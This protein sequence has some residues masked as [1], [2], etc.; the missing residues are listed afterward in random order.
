MSKLFC[1]DTYFW[2][3]INK[4]NKKVSGNIQARNIALAKFLLTKKNI[5]I[6]KIRKKLF[7][8]S[9]QFKIIQTIKSADV[10]IFIEHLIM[11][12]KSGMNLTTALN[13][14]LEVTK[15]HKFKKV[16]AQI[17]NDLIN[18]QSFYQA[19]NKY[20][21][22][23]D[24]L[25]CSLID[26][27]E[28]SSKLETVLIKLLSYKQHSQTIKRKLKKA[29]SYPLILLITGLLSIICIFIF[30]IPQFEIIFSDFIHELPALTKL[31]LKLAQF[32]N[33]KFLLILMI[34]LGIFFIFIKY[35]K[36]S[37]S[38]AIFLDKLILKLPF[39]DFL[40]LKITVVRFSYC[41]HIALDSGLPLT[42][43]LD[44]IKNSNNLFFNQCV[45]RI[46]NSITS[47][48]TL[49]TALKEVEVFPLLFINMIAVGEASGN[50]EKMLN[51]ITIM[52]E[53]EIDNCINIFLNILEPMIITILG[54]LLSILIIALYLPIFKLGSIF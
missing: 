43:A 12:L 47:G 37:L 8:I 7:N 4:Q 54:L 51:K 33:E 26:F 32:I 22:F 13:F 36:K 46:Q 5:K 15:N 28:K 27:G 34:I 21:Q 40:F 19:I 30:V 38:L 52:Y 9:F 44:L 45:L 24:S 39:G 1:N 17:N 25:S 49:N 16:I 10:I 29:L 50:L 11:M 18:G 6:I 41:L 20:P 31:I 2:I 14:I 42:K 48:K 3:G 53:E 23:F 35:K